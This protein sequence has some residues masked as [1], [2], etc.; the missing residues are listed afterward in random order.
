MHL[1]LWNVHVFPAKEARIDRPCPRTDHCQTDS[2]CRQN[3][4][5]PKVAATP[6]N[7]PNLSK[8]GQRTC[9]RRPQTQYEKYSNDCFD[10]RGDEYCSVLC[11]F[12][13]G[14]TIVNESDADQQS[15]GRWIKRP[16]PGQPFAK[17]ENNRCMSDPFKG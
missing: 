8:G 15:L 17:V 13:L 12:H 6:A 14:D 2:K 7:A 11:L 4:D 10:K 16:L 5:D 9:Y 3:D 1:A